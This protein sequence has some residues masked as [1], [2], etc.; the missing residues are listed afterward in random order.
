MTEDERLIYT[1]RLSEAQLKRHALLL[2]EAVEQF[3]DQNGEQVKY[4]KANIDALE[5]Y[6]AELEG[7]LY[8]TI[9]R[10]RARRPLGFIF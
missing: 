10:A 4:T 3:V 1:R 2:G 9:A 5:R 8:P 7:I 6:I